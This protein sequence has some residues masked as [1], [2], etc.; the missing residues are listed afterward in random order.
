MSVE[1]LYRPD[2][3]KAKLFAGE[4]VRLELK[5]DPF[6]VCNAVRERMFH[7]KPPEVDEAFE[8]VMRAR[9]ESSLG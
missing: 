7:V 9:K 8:R 2:T 4:A 3:D 6:A 5:G 1:V